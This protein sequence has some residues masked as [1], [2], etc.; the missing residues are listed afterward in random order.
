MALTGITNALRGIG[1]EFEVN[2]VIG[3]LGGLVYIIA[4]NVFAGYKL[5]A[6]GE[7]NLVEYCTA[8][9]GGVALVVGGT[10]GAVALKD[11]NVASAKITEKTGTVPAPPPAGPQTPPVD[12]TEPGADL[13]AK[14]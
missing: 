8:F 11:R 13:G 12:V 6:Q 1:G 14:I 4:A 5:F 3:A 10:A 9:P 2:R 7:F